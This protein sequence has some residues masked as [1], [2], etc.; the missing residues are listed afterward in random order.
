MKRTKLDLHVMGHLVL[1]AVE[2]GVIFGVLGEHGLEGDF[3][4][5]GKADEVPTGEDGDVRDERLEGF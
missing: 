1:H 3:G 2:S 5:A 4:H